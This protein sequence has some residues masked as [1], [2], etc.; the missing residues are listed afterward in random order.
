MKMHSNRLLPVVGLAWFVAILA[1]GILILQNGVLHIKPDGYDLVLLPLLVFGGALWMTKS[2]AP[3]EIPFI[4]MPSTLFLLLF[5]HFVGLGSASHYLRVVSGRSLNYS[6]SL[7]RAYLIS[8]LALGS[9]IVG[10]RAASLTRLAQ[11]ASQ[12]P[13]WDR[14]RL[15]RFSAILGVLSAILMTVY[16]YSFVG[17]MP[18]LSGRIAN[19][20][21]SLRQLVA[22]EGHY[23]SVL[24]FNA[25]M[26][27]IL[28]AG[29][30]LALFGFDSLIAL[31][32]GVEVALFVAWGPRIYFVLPL[33]VV[34]LLFVRKRRINPIWVSAVLLVSVVLLVVFGLWRNRA[35]VQL[36]QSDAIMLMGTSFSPEF[37]E[38]LSVLSYRE[39][40][41]KYYKRSTF[42]GAILF[43]TLP[44][45]IWKNFLGVDKT[46]IFSESSAWIIADIV[47]HSSWTGIRSGI[48][49]ELMITY[50]VPGVCIGFLILGMLF[51][52]LDRQASHNNPETARLLVVYLLAVLFSYLIIGQIESSFTR[53]WYALYA[54]L[55]ARKLA[56]GNHSFPTSTSEEFNGD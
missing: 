24:A 32:L 38:H 56:A 36:D 10:Y 25:N 46:A 45:I 31:L 54:F 39:V 26:M 8:T 16:L 19:V 4:S 44:N 37:R 52:F 48:I 18:S 11:G 50:D 49:S 14:K 1:I 42:W 20:D 53:L 30:Y 47:R 7:S 28:Y 55:L 6:E 33:L 34:G 17:G 21:D 51:L 41:S 27:A 29:T 23:I 35:E 9:W 43:T 13:S 40:L 3:A 12:S 22:G 15:K 2:R 5:V